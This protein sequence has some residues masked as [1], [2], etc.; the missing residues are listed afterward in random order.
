M[1]AWLP[2]WYLDFEWALLW[3]A[4]HPGCIDCCLWLHHLGIAPTGN[5]LPSALLD[6]PFTTPVFLFHYL[7][8]FCCWSPICLSLIYPC[9]INSLEILLS[10]LLAIV[11]LWEPWCCP[12][13]LWSTTEGCLSLLLLLLRQSHLP[14]GPVVCAFCFSS[15]SFTPCMAVQLLCTLYLAF[16]ITACKLSMEVNSWV[17]PMVS[18][19]SYPG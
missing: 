19:I 6:S 10:I 3:P 17:C 15:L 7:D 12:E 16:I 2:L 5:Y 9:Q 13:S 4:P 18:L 14:S 11:P 8:E 1:C